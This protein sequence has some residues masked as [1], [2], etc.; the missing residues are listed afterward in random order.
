MTKH[1]KLT[2]AAFTLLLSALLPV[3]A[4]A[5][6]APK[7][8]RPSIPKAPT[9]PKVVF[10]GDWVTYYWANAFAANP[11]WI[12]QGVPGA[13]LLGQGASSW[14]LSRFQ[15][16]VVNLHPAIVHIMVGSSDA[17]NDD[18]AV[19]QSTMPSFL[20]NLEA[21]VQQAQA[22]N[23]KVILGI[24]PSNLSDDSL[25]LEQ[26][27]SIIENY[28]AANN[29]P[30][31]DYEGAL[32]GAN[33]SGNGTA[34]AYTWTGG[35]AFT[36]PAPN[37]ENDGPIPS[38][39][40]YSVMTQMAESA[41]NTLSLTLKGGWLQ[42][43]Q[44]GNGN[45]NPLTATP[46]VNTVQPSAVLQFTPTGLYSDG[47]QQILLNTNFQGSNG[48]WTSSNPLVMYVSPTGMAW[49][50]SQGT[51]IIHYTPPSGVAFSEWIMYVQPPG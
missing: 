4:N 45:G 41:I 32:C 43:V 2:L 48:T 14:T 11:N 33:C 26:I 28:G 24:E 13:G 17:D 12:N 7:F 37:G 20:S 30:V 21:M 27:N 51:A 35:N 1:Q 47:S 25:Q 8:N 10:I 15:S 46:D 50:L 5:Q 18:D 44:Q 42:D 6:V 29:I 38:A 9:S 3:V 31:I 34:V 23:I 16:D 19:F 39:V 22:A 40:G 49:A 36:N